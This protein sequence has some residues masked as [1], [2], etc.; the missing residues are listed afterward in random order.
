[1]LSFRSS[2]YQHRTIL[3]RGQKDLLLPLNPLLDLVLR[4]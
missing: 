3:D 1:M 2:V 4:R